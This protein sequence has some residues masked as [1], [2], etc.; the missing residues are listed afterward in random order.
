MS[1][2]NLK[3]Q[4]QFSKGKIDVILAMAMVYGDFD[5]P[6]RRKDKASQACPFGKLRAGSEQRRMEP[7]GSRGAVSREE[8]AVS[9]PRVFPIY[10]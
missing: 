9:I 6:T 1:K 8:S 7:I 10:V 2:R 3:K 5:G 4:S